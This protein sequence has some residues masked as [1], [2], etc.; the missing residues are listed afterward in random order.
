[1][2]DQTEVSRQRKLR[3]EAREPR[4][5]APLAVVEGLRIRAVVVAADAGEHALAE[6]PFDPPVEPGLVVDL[7]DRVHLTLQRAGQIAGGIENWPVR[8][9]DTFV[10]AGLPVMNRPA[11]P[12]R[13]R[14]AGDTTL[15][16]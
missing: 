9:R 2:S 15:R 8:Q 13:L 11:A 6:L 5:P 1:M 4:V 7:R 12:A 10:Q 16:H 3:G 14:P